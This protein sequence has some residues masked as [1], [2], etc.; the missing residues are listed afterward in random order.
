[1]RLET[2]EGEETTPLAEA[3]DAI[4]EKIRDSRF[5][6]SLETYLEAL[7]KENYVQVFPKFGSSEWKATDTLEGAPGSAP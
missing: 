4:T 6:A 5:K 1:M 7:W 3:Q 2:K